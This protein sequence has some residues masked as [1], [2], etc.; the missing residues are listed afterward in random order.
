M[1]TTYYN[2]LLQKLERA[3]QAYY[4]NYSDAPLE[5][6]VGL[7][8][9]QFSVPS[10]TFIGQQGQET[11][12]GSGNFMCQLV[13]RVASSVDETS[14]TQHGTHV[15]EVFDMFLRDDIATKLGGAEGGQSN[16]HVLGTLNPRVS[17]RTE[18]R[19]QVSELELECYAAS[20]DM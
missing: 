8:D 16:F 10:V 5:S 6:Y 7:N 2:S 11:P 3:A 15:G 9:V 20:S 13:I 17:E 18:E 19:L 12:Q 1:P 14:A 4:D